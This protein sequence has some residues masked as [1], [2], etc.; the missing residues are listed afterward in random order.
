MLQ[1]EHTREANRNIKGND[2]RHVDDELAELNTQAVLCEQ[3]IEDDQAFW[4]ADGFRPICSNDIFW[5]DG[6]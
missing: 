5:L 3:F 1:L 4:L 2:Y 6:Q